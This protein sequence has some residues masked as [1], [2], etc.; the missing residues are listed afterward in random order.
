M[1][2]KPSQPAQKIAG[3]PPSSKSR[4]IS[5]QRR[6]ELREA[7]LARRFWE[8]STGPRTPEGKLR[9]AA[10]GKARQ[11]GKHTVRERQAMLADT[12][13]LMA[14]LSALRRGLADRVELGGDT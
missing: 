8:Y 7:A 13:Q 4:E 10:N 5:E 6:Q 3:Q 11:K 2:K 12:L 1:P 9:S 14:R